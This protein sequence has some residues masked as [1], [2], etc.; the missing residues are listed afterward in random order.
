MESKCV[1]ITRSNTL[2][3]KKCE[4]KYCKFHEYMNEYT[5]DMMNNLTL[6]SGCKKQYYIINA[7]ICNNCKE[8]KNKIKETKENIIC[9]Y[10]GDKPCKYKQDSELKNG[11][12]GKHMIYYWKEEQEKNGLKVCT[13]YVRGCRNTFTDEFARCIECRT[14]ERDIEKTRNNM[15]K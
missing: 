11:Y 8:R 10:S 13:N 9:K 4:N 12:C 6:C 15:R 2:C 14:K 1:G 7:R 3:N 5:I